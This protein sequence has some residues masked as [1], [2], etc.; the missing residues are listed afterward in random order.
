MSNV[1]Y[2]ID[3]TGRAM[4]RVASEAAL[5][6]RGKTLVDYQRHLAPKLEVHIG[7]VGKMNVSI[8][9][10][11]TKTYSR[12]T[13]YPG[14]LRQPSLAKVIEK[15]GGLSEPLRLAIKGMLPRNKLRDVLLKQLHLTE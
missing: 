13:G 10:R 9:K 12:Y 14:G 2:K 8:L 7:N 5:A 11:E 3:A 1:V 4:G 6:L 15:H